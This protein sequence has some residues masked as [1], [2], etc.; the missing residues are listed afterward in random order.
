MI[1]YKELRWGNAFSYGLDNSIKLNTSALTQ[2]IGVNGSGKS[3][4]ALILEEVLFNQNCKKVK[5]G[6]ILNRH[7]KDKS[8]TIE[9][10]L[11]DDTHEYT[12]KTSR[13]NTTSTVKLL[14]GGTDISSHTS[15]ATYKEI[16]RIIGYDYKTFSQIVYQSSAASLEFLTAT[17]SERKQFLIELLNLSK[18]SKALDTFKKLA[19]DASKQVDIT[20]AKVNTTQIW[21]TKHKSSSLATQELEEVPQ[22][23]N[24]EISELADT[25]TKLVNIE[26]IN[27]KITENNKY[28]KLILDNVLGSAPPIAPTVASIND[29]KLTVAEIRRELKEGNALASNCTSAIS[30]CTSCNQ[31]I[32]NST[33]FTLVSK[34]KLDKPILEGKVQALLKEID[35]AETAVTTWNTYSS[36][37]LEVNRYHELLDPKLEKVLLDKTDLVTKI[38]ALEKRIASITDLIKETNA[39]NTQATIHNAKVALLVTQ[40]EEMESSLAELDAE[41]LLKSSELS[42]LQVLVKAFSNTGLVAYKIEGLVKDLESIT[43]TYLQDMSGGRFSLSFK[44]TSA[45]KLNVVINDNGE[46]VEITSLSTGERARVNISALLAIRKLTQSLSN[47]RSNLLIL[48][49]TIDNLD[50]SGKEQLVE[51]LL[52]EPNLNTIIVSHGFSHPLL[53]KI[54][55]IKTKNI[56]RLE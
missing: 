52:A 56:S 47:S 51:I 54:N 36:K 41:L 28:H 20:S 8:Y 40:I 19:S 49:E 6:K 24:T 50:A 44:I 53:E 18:Y 30:K 5:K 12:I 7:T 31:D 15:T 39:R 32:D 16:E 29:L 14:R 17:D 48:D 22:Q 26:S 46:D 25:R 3:S 27:K 13:T 38:S 1:T 2:L 33:K 9:L 55:V 37:V 23:P 42:K 43:N 10:D 45:D 34:F 4:I 11:S 35:T 21:L